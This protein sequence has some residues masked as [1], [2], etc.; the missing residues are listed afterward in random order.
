MQNISA[1]TSF[2]R[3]S[4]FFLCLCSSHPPTFLLIVIVFTLSDAVRYTRLLQS[5]WLMESVLWC[6]QCGPVTWLRFPR[7]RWL[8][9]A[10]RTGTPLGSVASGGTA[11][12]SSH[13]GRDLWPG[14]CRPLC[15]RGGSSGESAPGS[16]CL[17]P[18]IKCRRSGGRLIRGGAWKLRNLRR[19]R[20][21]EG[22]NTEELILCKIQHLIEV[23]G[24]MF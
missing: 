3:F 21:G 13:P 2:S 5:N 19:G 10:Q 23:F 12:L 4:Q 14:R 1:D 6:C 15:G 8:S 7:P 9:P 24:L 17:P 20:R 22:L 16:D 18:V 11:S